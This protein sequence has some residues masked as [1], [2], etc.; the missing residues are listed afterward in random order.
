MRLHEAEQHQLERVKMD[1]FG[2]PYT[3]VAGELMK[4]FIYAIVEPDEIS[5]SHL[6]K[7]VDFHIELDFVL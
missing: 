7:L 4:A 6:T 1:R 2:F 5:R 3:E